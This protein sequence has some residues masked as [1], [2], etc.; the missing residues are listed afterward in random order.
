MPFKLQGSRVV[1]LEAL[2]A[3]PAADQAEPNGT[4]PDPDSVIKLPRAPSGA[5]P[6][7]H[8]IGLFVDDGAN[9]ATQRDAVEVTFTVW[10]KNSHSGRWFFL[11][12]ITLLHAASA[13]TIDS[14]PDADI[15]IQ[16][17]AIGGAGAAEGDKVRFEVGVLP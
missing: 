3:I 4:E 10:W 17:T 12:N 15:F 7:G 11:P 1:T 16:V 9:P 8:V 14:I 13:T 6:R 5:P 2:A